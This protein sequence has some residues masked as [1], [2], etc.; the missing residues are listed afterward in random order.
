[1]NW[2]GSFNQRCKVYNQELKRKCIPKFQVEKKLPRVVMTDQ[3]QKTKHVASHKMSDE[4][5][6]A[7]LI[8]FGDKY[9]TMR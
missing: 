6:L 3:E 9:Y 2:R 7:I 4:A 8:E 5:V 1:M